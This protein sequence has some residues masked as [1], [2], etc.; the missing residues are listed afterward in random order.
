MKG[1]LVTLGLLSCQIAPVT[2]TAT[3]FYPVSVAKR[4]MSSSCR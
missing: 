2:T 4:A 3:G 1:T